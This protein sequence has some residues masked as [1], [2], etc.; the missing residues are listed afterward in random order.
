MGRARKITRDDILDAAERV[1]VRHGAAGLSIDAVAQ[2]AGISKATVVYD[3]KSKSALLAALVERRVKADMA[4]VAAGVEAAANTP[5]PELFGRIRAAEKA[6]TDTDRAVAIAVSAS[7][8]S[9]ASLQ[10]TMRD[11]TAMDLAAMSQGENPKAALLAYLALTGFIYTELFGFHEWTGRER[12]EILDS[13]RSVY[14]S[15]ADRA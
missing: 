9:E 5:H 7:M 15:Y 4:D 6:V 13:I 12:E 11:W 14:R 8:S 2:E 1:V 10:Q 3:H